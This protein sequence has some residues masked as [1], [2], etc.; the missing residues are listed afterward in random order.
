[1]STVYPEICMFCKHLFNEKVGQ[2]QYKCKAFPDGVPSEIYQGKYDHRNPY[3][4]DSGITFELENEF[5]SDQ[6]EVKL[7][8]KIIESNRR[9]IF[10]NPMKISPTSYDWWKS[11]SNE[12]NETSSDI[13]D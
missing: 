1:M 8:F 13:E 12:G 11:E 7:M 6:D 9:I 3:P 10:D 5:L 4:N 2:N